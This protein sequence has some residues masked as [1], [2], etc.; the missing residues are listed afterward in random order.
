MHQQS[1]AIQILKRADSLSWNENRCPLGNRLLVNKTNHTLSMHEPEGMKLDS[2]YVKQPL[3]I[4][5]P[6]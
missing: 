2:I 5:S 4:M 1:V 3:N 6:K